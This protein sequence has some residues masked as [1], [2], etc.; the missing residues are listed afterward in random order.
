MPDPQTTPNYLVPGARYM[1]EQTRECV[2]RENGHLVTPVYESRADDN[3]N[4]R[5]QTPS[6]EDKKDNHQ[7]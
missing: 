6:A 2:I 3:H 1:T 4:C 7:S 5:T